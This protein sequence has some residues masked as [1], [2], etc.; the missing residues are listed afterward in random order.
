MLHNPIKANGKLSMIQ[1]LWV[2]VCVHVCLHPSVLCEFPSGCK[3]DST[4]NQHEPE[5]CMGSEP[6]CHWS[7]FNWVW[8]WE[9]Q[10]LRGGG[11][12]RVWKA[13]WRCENLSILSFVPL[14]WRKY[15][16]ICFKFIYALRIQFLKFLVESCAM[17][18]WVL[19]FVCMCVCGV[20]CKKSKS[21]LENLKVPSFLEHKVHQVLWH[22]KWNKIV[23]HCGMTTLPR[24][25]VEAK[26]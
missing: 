17:V 6:H 18:A 21:S 23:D 16:S 22:I 8:L 11:G 9:L 14:K 15:L 20:S 3:D 2:C 1:K 24:M 4:P 10:S 26:R 25:P 7:A 12:V 13:G 19:F 5:I